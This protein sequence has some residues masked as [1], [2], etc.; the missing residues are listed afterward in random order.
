MATQQCFQ[1]RTLVCRH[2]ICD[3]QHRTPHLL[4][5]TGS[6]KVSSACA[7][8]FDDQTHSIGR[9]FCDRFDVGQ[10]ARYRVSGRSTDI[11]EFLFP[12]PVV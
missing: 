5:E 6:Q 2:P 10:I 11:D 1:D 4:C 3:C 7:I 12:R 9:N 8:T